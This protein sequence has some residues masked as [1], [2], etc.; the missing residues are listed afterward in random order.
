MHLNR[1]GFGGLATGHFHVQNNE[2]EDISVDNTRPNYSFLFVL[3]V[4]IPLRHVCKVFK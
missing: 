3:K 2:T 1:L 4:H